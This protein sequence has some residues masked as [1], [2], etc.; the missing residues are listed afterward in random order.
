MKKIKGR[1]PPFLSRSRG[2]WGRGGAGFGAIAAPLPE[3]MRA[4]CGGDWSRS[5]AG[6]D[7]VPDY[8]M[9]GVPQGSGLGPVLEPQQLLRNTSADG[10]AALE[11]RHG[12]LEFAPEEP[13]SDL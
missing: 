4:S 12:N 3:W 10:I 13:W 8:V 6:P 2:Q 9:A 11:D 7:Q 1:R 5:Q